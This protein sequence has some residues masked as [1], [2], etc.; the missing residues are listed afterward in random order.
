MR[1]EELL[2]TMVRSYFVITTGV[3]VSLF[4]FCRIFSPDA[5]FSLRDVGRILL[6]GLWGDLPHLI[7]LSSRELDRKQML[8]RSILHALVLTG[9]LLTCAIRWQWIN[10]ASVP[11]VAV[12]LLSVFGVYALVIIMTDRR[13]RKLTDRINLRLRERYGP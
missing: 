7:F 8:L 6:M 2:K 9:L 12:F 10:P 3:A 13:D 1:K 5:V 11:E 4:V